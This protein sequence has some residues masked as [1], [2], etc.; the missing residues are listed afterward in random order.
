M[1]FVVSRV[2]MAV[3]A[4]LVLSVLSGLY[5]HD[6]LADREAEL[7][8]LLRSFCATADRIAR[9]GAECVVEWRVP[10]LSVGE[11]VVVTVNAG[12]VRASSGGTTVFSQPSVELRTWTLQDRHL[13]EALLQDLDAASDEV[14]AGSGHALV[15]RS[16]AVVVGGDASLLVFVSRAA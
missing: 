9:S 13:T 10:Y 6:R 3:C 15:L 1:D 7:E 4:L 14:C 5:G 8:Q 2:A 12:L 11:A 16:C